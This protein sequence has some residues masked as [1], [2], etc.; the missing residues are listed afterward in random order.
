MTAIDR[1][2]A[3]PNWHHKLFFS[4]FSRKCDLRHTKR[5]TIS[6]IT[7]ILASYND[8]IDLNHPVDYN[9]GIGRSPH[10]PVFV[11]RPTG[12]MHPGEAAVSVSGIGAMESSSGAP[13]ARIL[14][15]AS[16]R[17]RTATERQ[18]PVKNVRERNSNPFRRLCI[19]LDDPSLCRMVPRRPSSFSDRS[20]RPHN[21]PHLMSKPYQSRP[22]GRDRRP[23]VSL[24]RPEAPL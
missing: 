12:T 10:R 21:H 17:R 2:Y 13:F 24:Q 16:R 15:Q 14:A 8:F 6:L 20:L 18:G 9:G 19:E 1:G 3:P 23:G 4:E 11:L 7:N 22:R 5:R